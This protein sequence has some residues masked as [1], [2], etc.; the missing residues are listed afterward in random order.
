MPNVALLLFPTFSEFE[1]S[2]ALSLLRDSHDLVT[3]ALSDEV[4]TS[5]AGLQVLP[6]L[7]IDQAD[8]NDY[9]ALLI[10][11]GD[12]I[13]LME[14]TPVFEFVQRMN[15]QGKL[16][17]A[18]CGGGYVLAKAGVLVKPYTVNFT[19]EQR[20]F[21]GCFEENLFRREPF[22]EEDNIFTAQGHT[23]VEFGLRVAER[24][25]PELSDEVKRFY[26]G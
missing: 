6:H 13:H 26:R 12:M 14:A 7:N 21:L 10:P 23:Y 15:Q 5:E 9:D 20:D 8:A 2:V 4:V 1:V 3:L 22:V 11:G 18:I 17:A 19:K 25:N 24:L 16:L